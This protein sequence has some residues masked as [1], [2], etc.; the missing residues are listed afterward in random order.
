MVRDNQLFLPGTA[1]LFDLDGVLVDSDAD[2]E[3]AWSAWAHGYGLSPAQVLAVVH[4]RRTADT[5]ADFFTSGSDAESA[6]ARIDEL[7]LTGVREAVAIEGAPALT[8]SLRSD[9]WAVVTSGRRELARARLQAAG[10]W[11]VPVLVAAEDVTAGKPAPDCYLRAA[12]ALGVDPAATI[13][14]EDAVPG[15]RA[16]RS[17]GVG[18]V[19]GVGAR[20][21][22]SEADAVVADLRAATWGGDGLRIDR[23]AA[24][25]A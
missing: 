17:A 11:P 6:L 16:A 12:A 3:A 22:D 10:I 19:L 15:V 7:E 13:V 23:S 24:L 25:R 1:V 8:A 4:G 18:Q 2:V 21:V 5:V 9:R 14:I 20:A